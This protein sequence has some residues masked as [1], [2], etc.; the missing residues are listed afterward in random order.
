MR[1][2]CDFILCCLDV[3]A[4][5][6]GL[7]VHKSFLF[8]CGVVRAL[9]CPPW[10]I[11]TPPCCP[12]PRAGEAKLRPTCPASAVIILL[13]N[14]CPSYGQARK[15]IMTYLPS[16]NETYLVSPACGGDVE[17]SE[18][19]RARKAR[20]GA[21]A[22]RRAGEGPRRHTHKTPALPFWGKAGVYLHDLCGRGPAFC[23]K[24]PFGGGVAGGRQLMRGPAQSM[25]RFGGPVY[26]RFAVSLYRPS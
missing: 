13:E 15:S 14:T 26:Q 8:S 21:D 6:M 25:A 17:R 16:E 24:L 18:T 23:R 10:C 20:R 12:P 2:F 1:M 3:Y 19:E 22:P 7:W 9:T 4:V 11:R 5:L